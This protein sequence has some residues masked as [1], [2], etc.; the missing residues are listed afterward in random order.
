MEINHFVGD[1]LIAMILFP[2]C[3]LPKTTGMN[4][5]DT[6]VCRTSPADQHGISKIV[7]SRSV[8]SLSLQPTL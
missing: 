4:Q 2:V 1:L 8:I 3:R 6:L 7:A 5:S